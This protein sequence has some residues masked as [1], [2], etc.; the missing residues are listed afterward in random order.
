M[1]SHFVLFL[2]SAFCSATVFV[3]GALSHD[4][5]AFARR[6]RDGRYGFCT[7]LHQSML[8]ALRRQLKSASATPG[9]VSCAWF[10]EL[11][12]GGNLNTFFLR[13]LFYDCDIS[14]KV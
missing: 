10:T 6:E 5:D 2:P 3:N 14:L 1:L 12:E 7:S 8:V 13:T 4:F 9:N 11:N